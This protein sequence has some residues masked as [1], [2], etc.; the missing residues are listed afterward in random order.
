MPDNNA[1]DQTDADVE[2][3][4]SLS[5]DLREFLAS[6]DPVP[7]PLCASFTL[8]QWSASCALRCGISVEDFTDRAE[9]AWRLALRS[10]VSAAA[11]GVLDPGQ[12]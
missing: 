10:A 12:N 4:E 5:R 11:G 6:R 1:K 3:F 9:R 8:L 2:E 7:D